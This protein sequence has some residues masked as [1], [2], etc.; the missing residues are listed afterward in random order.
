M[1]KKLQDEKQDKLTNPLTQSDVVNNL[2]SDST[3]TPLSAYQGKVLHDALNKIYSNWSGTGSFTSVNLSS[4][5]CT[6]KKNNNIVDFVLSANNGI[7]MSANVEDKIGQISA[8]YR[9]PHTIYVP[10]RIQYSSKIYC[11]VVIIYA[12]GNMYLTTPVALTQ[13]GGT[14][15]I[16]AIYCV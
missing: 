6:I 8:N 7:A 11:G 1:G 3:S 10:A 5:S 15:K 13:G 4:V 12:D 9:P 16:S 14:V 2:T